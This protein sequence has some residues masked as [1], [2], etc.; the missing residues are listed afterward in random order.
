MKNVHDFCQHNYAKAHIGSFKI[1]A[2]IFNIGEKNDS[3]IWHAYLFAVVPMEYVKNTE[4]CIKQCLL[5]IIYLRNNKYVTLFY[6]E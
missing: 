1:L 2:I 5:L 4:Q 6:G 3:K